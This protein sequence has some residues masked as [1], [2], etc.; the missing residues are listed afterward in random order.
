MVFGRAQVGASRPKRI[1]ALSTAFAAGNNLL[2]AQ[3]VESVD[4]DRREG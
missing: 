4:R 3:V 2:S 1:P